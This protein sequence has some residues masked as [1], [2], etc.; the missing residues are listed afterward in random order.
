MNINLSLPLG[1]R[2]TRGTAKTAP[3]PEITGYDRN[4]MGE[5]QKLAIMQIRGTARR[6]TTTMEK[7]ER[8]AHGLTKLIMWISIPHQMG[9]IMDKTTL[10]WG[11]FNESL[12]SISALMVA[13]GMP[14]VC[15]ILTLLA[16]MLV[17]APVAYVW[18]RFGGFILMIP[19]VAGSSLINYSAPGDPE[20]R[21]MVCLMVLGIPI[22]Q[23][24]RALA[25]GINWAQ[26]IKM[27]EKVAEQVGISTVVETPASAGKFC[28]AG[29]TCGKHTPRKTTPP[30][31]Q[32]PARKART[33]SKATAAAAAAKKA[34]VA[35]AAKLEAEIGDPNLSLLDDAAAA[36]AE[37]A[38]AEAE[39]EM[40]RYA[41]TTR[42]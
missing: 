11:G 14:F 8:G 4:R 10:N 22:A 35:A 30:P 2:I 5:T 40:A 28:P 39:A 25:Q 37:L 13:G 42:A 17:G 16:V 6:Q 36:A 1:I 38:I 3:E 29:C 19:S 26:M 21:K 27:E 20:I 33:S 34:A 18:A 9:Y 15:D 31:V 41:E 23:G 12:H 7:I 32:P 24:I